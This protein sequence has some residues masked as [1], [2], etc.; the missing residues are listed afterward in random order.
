MSFLL[1]TNILSHHMRG[2]PGLAHRFIQHSGRLAMP[3]IVLA[4]L[5]AEA[6]LPKDPTPL[7]TQVADMLTFI[8]VLAFDADC[9][10]A[11]GRLRG[12]LH[13]RGLVVPPIDLL[14]A[15]VAVAS[16]LTLVTRH[17]QH[18]RFRQHSRPAGRGLVEPV[19]RKVPQR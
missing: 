12:D 15:S 6:H 10:E 13:R 2:A 19:C 9:A 5:Y 17:E 8:D 14:I 3:A 1:D 18:G 16:D 7:L 4:E 11:F